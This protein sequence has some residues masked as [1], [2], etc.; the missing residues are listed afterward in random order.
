MFLTQERSVLHLTRL[1]SHE[2]VQSSGSAFVL[3]LL[4]NV[5]VDIWPAAEDT[6]EECSN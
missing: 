1:I 6:V 3:Q 2:P 4:Q 5:S